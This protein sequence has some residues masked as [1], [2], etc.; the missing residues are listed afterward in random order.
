MDSATL[1]SH[2]AQGIRLQESGQYL[3]AI[4]SF[5]A[6]LK[7]S[8][9]HP[10]TCY[11]Y[12]LSLIE[13][14]A[15]DQAMEMLSRAIVALPEEATFH[16]ALGSLLQSQG[17]YHPALER[18]HEAI[19]L[20]PNQARNYFLAG[21][22]HMDL[23]QLP[24]AITQFREA[25]RLQPDFKEAAVNLG[26]CLKAQKDLDAALGLFDY[27][28][29]LD[30]GHLPARLNRALTLLL[31][32]RYPEGWAA[33]DCR[34]QLPEVIEQM[35]RLP[36]GLRPWQGEPLLG[37][38][39]LILAEQGFGDNIQFVRYLPLVKQR[40]AETLLE[41]P[42][43]LEPLFRRHPGVDAV[44]NRAQVTRDGQ[45]ADYYC[46]LLS[47]PGL[48]GT[49]P[50]TIPATVPYLHPLPDRVA[51]WRPRIQGDGLKVGLFWEGKP[52]HRNDLARRRS[53]R[54]KDLEPLLALPGLD[55]FSFQT[56]DTTTRTGFRANLPQPVALG[57]DLANFEETAAALS[58][59]DLLITIDTAIAH[60]AGALGKPVW[61]LTPLAPD[62]RWRLDGSTNPWYP[63][64][65]LFRQR[66]PGRWEQPV[67]E[68]A[69]RLKKQKHL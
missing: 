2:L 41:C 28:L 62:W 32:E 56:P 7:E 55:F 52:L 43:T 16:Q 26:L 29:S 1:L 34:F 3:E 33:Y 5:Q 13:T 66:Q 30:P 51:A 46:P 42:V 48:L 54:P 23:G 37:K 8:P 24:E 12:G 40:G 21:D 53:C 10:H 15:P 35:Q 63:T 59:V 17:L 4:P 14:N 69:E 67:Q 60:L 22:A 27:A 50:D 61:L 47:L 68:I 9:G 19:R 39:L 49:T 6:I 44:T 64:M 57:A 20:A 45:Q 65:T 38:R 25:L 31:A 36:G 58:L 11:L 18:L